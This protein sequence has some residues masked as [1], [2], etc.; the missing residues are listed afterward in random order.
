MPVESEM[1]NAI[2]EVGEW[3]VGPLLCAVNESVF[4]RSE[5]SPQESKKL[6]ALFD[7]YEEAK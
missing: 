1:V 6:Q 2:L 7:K 5:I 4:P 3:S